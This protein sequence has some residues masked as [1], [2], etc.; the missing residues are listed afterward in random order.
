MSGLLVA[1]LP[2]APAPLLDRLERDLG[3]A[4]ALPVRRSGP[5]AEPAGAW[6]ETRGQ[7]SATDFLRALVARLPPPP[8]RLLGVTE[9]DLFVPVLSFVFG[10]AQ[11]HGRAAVV[12]LARLRPEFHGL[13]P[14]DPL[15]ERRAAKEAVHEVGHTFGLVHCLDRACPMS[16]S[17]DLPDLDRKTAEPCPSCSALLEGSLEMQRARAQAEVEPR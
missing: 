12:S 17:I 10:Q 7:W 2:S 14:D 9:H 16:L 3:R 1:P 11:L 4:F 13:P 8:C 5:V 6:S 15:L